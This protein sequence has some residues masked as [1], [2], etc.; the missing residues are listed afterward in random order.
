MRSSTRSIRGSALHRRC[1]P[2]QWLSLFLVLSLLSCALVARGARASAAVSASGSSG[3]VT[4]SFFYS[5]L[6][7]YGQWIDYPPYGYCWVPGAVAMDWRPY[8]YGQW[9]Y[10][11]FGWTWASDEPWG[12]AVYHYG[13]WFYDPAYGWLWAPG[14]V[15]GPAWVEWRWSDDAVGWAPLPPAASWGVQSGLSFHGAAGIPTRGWSFVEPR[16]FVDGNLRR[17]MFPMAQNSMLLSRTHDITRIAVRDGRP[18]NAAFESNAIERRTGRRVNRLTVVDEP[19]STVGRGHFQ[20]QDEIGFY[21]PSIGR[22]PGQDRWRRSQEDRRPPSQDRGPQPTSPPPAQ[23]RDD[24]GR[25]PHHGGHG[26]DSGRQAGHDHGD[27]DKDK[28]KEDSH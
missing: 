11:D 3:R 1:D 10:T 15:W 9:V 21:R 12:W 17:R 18:F 19:S 13:R 6:E 28:G 4:Y 20:G 14:E 25:W 8:W 26:P 27:R 22:A 16:A 23:A 24:R 7:P 5:D 2:H